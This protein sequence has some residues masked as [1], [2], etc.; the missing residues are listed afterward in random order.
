MNVTEASAFNRICDYLGLGRHPRHVEAE[1][2]IGAFRILASRSN[3]CLAAGISTIEIDESRPLIARF[4]FPRRVQVS[5]TSGPN[6]WAEARERRPSSNPDKDDLIKVVYEGSRT[7]A[8]VTE[9]R[10]TWD[11]HGA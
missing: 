9:P 1:E 6:R 8:W 5:Q 10:V 4:E 11:P 2:A 7:S 3:Q